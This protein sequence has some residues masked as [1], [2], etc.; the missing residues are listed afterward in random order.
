MLAVR[1]PRPNPMINTTPR[2][3]FKQ[4]PLNYKES[5][6]IKECSSDLVK[7]IN[8]NCSKKAHHL[9][10]NICNQLI[11]SLLEHEK[12]QTSTPAQNNEEFHQILESISQD[13]IK[14]YLLINVIKRIKFESSEEYNQCIASKKTR[15]K[16]AN[17]LIKKFSPNLEMAKYY[18]DKFENIL[19]TEN[20]L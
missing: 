5:K 13:I 2:P 18:N 14:K 10:T 16:I 12:I 6:L 8:N 17:L 11:D 9:I 7:E 15:R 4:K 19:N 3:N 1:H 20:M